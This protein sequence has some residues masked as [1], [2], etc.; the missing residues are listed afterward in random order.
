M[1]YHT[2]SQ[3]SIKENRKYRPIITTLTPEFSVPYMRQIP[4]M[5]NQYASADLF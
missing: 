2:L 3:L 5:C 1:L 4:V